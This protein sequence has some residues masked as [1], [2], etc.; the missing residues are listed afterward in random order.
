MASIRSLVIAALAAAAAPLGAQQW[1]GGAPSA[2]KTATVKPAKTAKA[3]ASARPSQIVV[4]DPTLS[5][6]PLPDPRTVS[7]PVASGG[8]SYG[9]IAVSN[10]GGSPPAPAASAQ[11]TTSGQWSNPTSW[12]T[13]TTAGRVIT[14]PSYRLPADSA[15]SASVRKT[16]KP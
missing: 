1:G 16:K 4:V 13:P 8:G 12:S 3:K 9:P 11:T 5:V 14:S 10:W 7:A 6:A 15:Q 2:A